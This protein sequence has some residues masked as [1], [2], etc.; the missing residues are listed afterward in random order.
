MKIQGKMF[1][2]LSFFLLAMAVLYG[3][4]SKEAV[5]TTAL[6]MAFGLAIMVGYYLAFTARR[7][8]AMAQDDK[9]ADVADEAGELGFFSPHS[10]QPLALAVG[11]A[12]AFLAVALDWWLMFFSLP[13]ILIG[14]WGWVFEYY[15]GEN[16]NQ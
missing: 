4:W 2:W 7:V 15:R 8:D 6:F 10:W 12:F 14:I 16:Q 13:I 9:E 11:G 5:G 1:I 3:L